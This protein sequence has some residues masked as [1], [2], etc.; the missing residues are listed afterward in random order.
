MQNI[1]RRDSCCCFV[2][3]ECCV[4]CVGL[5]VCEFRYCFLYFMVSH[6]R[7]MMLSRVCKFS[8]IV[9]L[10]L[11]FCLPC[12]FRWH[13]LLVVFI[14]IRFLLS[15]MTPNCSL[16]TFYPEHFRITSVSGYDSILHFVLVTVMEGPEGVGRWKD[17]M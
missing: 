2:G 5:F 16:A 3:C 1:S 11:F 12:A 17:G 6:I 13:Y 8:E 14:K 7:V 10:D 9:L 15:H 4:I